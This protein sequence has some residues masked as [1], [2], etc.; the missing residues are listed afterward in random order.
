V[1]VTA[2]EG[3]TGNQKGAIAEAE[4]C[5]A[6]VRREIPVFKPVAEHGRCE[7]VLELGGRPSE[8]NASGA[9]WSV[10]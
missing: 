7:V 6:A 1:F 3:L 2:M 9:R 10:T 4:I 5:A 8:S